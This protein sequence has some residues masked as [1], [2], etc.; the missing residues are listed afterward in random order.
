MVMFKGGTIVEKG[1]YWSPT[2]GRRIDMQ[3]GGALPGDA[4]HIYLKISAVELA[5]IA[6]L[7]GMMYVMFLPLFGMGVFIVSWIIIA[8]NSLAKVTMIG[9]Q[10]CGRVAGRGL[11]FNWRPS[12]ASFS[13]VVKKR[14]I[15]GKDIKK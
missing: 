13:G 10:V 6:P 12:D 2:D 14:K 4:S 7:F 11:I 15:R 5:V 1:L 9:I 8:V 3:H